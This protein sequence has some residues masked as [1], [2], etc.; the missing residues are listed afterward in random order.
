MKRAYQKPGIYIENL[1]LSQS[2]ASG[3]TI[4]DDYNKPNHA[5]GDCGW[6][7]GGSMV[8]WADVTM[9]CNKFHDLDTPFSEVCYDNPGGAMSLFSS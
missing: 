2:I 5:R 9:H 3:C 8:L 4:P 7:I 6:E 1:T